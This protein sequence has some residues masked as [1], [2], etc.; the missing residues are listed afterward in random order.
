MASDAD[1][2]R[3]ARTLCLETEGCCCVFS[4]VASCGNADRLY[5]RFARAAIAAMPGQPP[6]MADAG[7]IGDLTPG[8]IT[9]VPMGWRPIETAPRD[10]H[11]QILGKLP[12]VPA[13]SAYYVAIG[14]YDSRRKVWGDDE[15]DDFLQQPTHW[16]PLPDPP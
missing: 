5:S 14:S 2:K 10:G 9:F 13:G 8:P 12:N 1:V 4:E 11:R 15:G 7:E 16:M 6:L 3:I